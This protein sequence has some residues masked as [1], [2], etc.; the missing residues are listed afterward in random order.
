MLEGYHPHKTTS[1]DMRPGRALIE[2]DNSQTFAVSEPSLIWPTE[3][4]FAFTLVP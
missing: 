3:I 2:T 4:S 1:N